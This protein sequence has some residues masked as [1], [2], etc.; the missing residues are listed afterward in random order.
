MIHPDN[1]IIHNSPELSADQERE[2]KEKRD[3]MRNVAN[4]VK[5][6]PILKKENHK[7]HP[8]DPEQG[9]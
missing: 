4:G 3:E 5:E 8:N 9:K 6:D 2:M 7:P 1:N